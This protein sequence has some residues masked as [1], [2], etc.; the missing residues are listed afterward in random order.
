[1]KFFN[2]S[3]N[4]SLKYQIIIGITLIQGLI[5]ATFVYDSIINQKEKIEEHALEEAE[6]ISQVYSTG[7]SSLVFSRDYAGILEMNNDVSK[8]EDAKYAFVYLNDGKIIAHS[9][10]KNIGKFVSDK[11]SIDGLLNQNK[12]FV[13]DNNYS[14]ADVANPILF[15]NKIIGWVRLGISKESGNNLIHKIILKGAFAFIISIFLGFIFSYWI[16]SKITNDLNKL[17]EMAKK[18]ESG[19]HSARAIILAE[20]EIGKLSKVFNSMLDSLV[21]D[22]LELQKSQSLLKMSEER[23]DLA[24]KSTNDA[25]WDFNTKTGEVYFSDRWFEILGSKKE[26]KSY[27]VS[28]WRMRVHPDDISKTEQILNDHINGKTDYYIAEHRLKHNDGFYIWTIG[29]G[30]GIKGEDGLVYR[31][32][33]TQSNISAQKNAEIEKEKIYNQ[34]QQ[35]QKMEAIGQLTGGIAHDFNNILAGVIGFSDLGLKRVNQDEKTLGYL[36]HISKL[37]NRARDLVKQM[38]IYSRGGDPIAKNVDTVAIIEESLK[39]LEPIFSKNI[40]ISVNHNN[41]KPIIKIDPTQLQQVI[42]NI[43]INA[44]DAFNDSRGEIKINIEN[45]VEH[46]LDCTSC[47][48]IISGNYVRISISDNASGID[49]ITLKKIFEPFFT[50]KQL[51]K[52]TGMGLAMVHGI[53]HRQNGHIYVESKINKGSTFNFYLPE[54]HELLD[55]NTEIISIKKEIQNYKKR[56]LIVDDEDFLRNFVN[57]FLT[58]NGCECFEA[59]NG[60][61]ALE[62][63]KQNPTGVDLVITDFTMPELNG[64]ELIE[65]IRKDWP[66]LPVILSSG[67]LDLALD[68][69]YKHLNID[70]ILVKPYEID[71]ALAIV[72]NLLNATKKEKVA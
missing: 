52:G 67:N 18:V 53:I 7:I 39:L 63:L 37:A 4:I 61:K 30:V 38:M 34:L 32:V 72:N 19:D 20:N 26:N 59:E 49:E 58:D 68:K 44:K 62:F 11:K 25:I 28:E 55:A 43:I 3:L 13:V 12:F 66:Y 51:G 64:I 33:G 65:K 46:G 5:S 22:K 8:Y 14:Y 31:M 2:K 10:E 57:E 71:D 6:S 56:V 1:M 40:K 35:S 45:A 42:T 9:D 24:L 23:F 54:V 69:D 36:Y 29:R 47:G 16:A 70:A 27:D 60:I 48:H 21:N 41:F 50:T 15:Q 17:F